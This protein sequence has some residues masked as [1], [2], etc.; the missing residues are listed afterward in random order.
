LIGGVSADQRVRAEEA[1]RR[2]EQKLRETQQQLTRASCAL[3][4][5]RF[6]LRTTLT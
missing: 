2:L 1:Q 4:S 5:A 3:A 6:C